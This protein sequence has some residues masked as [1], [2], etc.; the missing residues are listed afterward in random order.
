MMPKIA[1][2]LLI[3]LS[4]GACATEWPPGF[5]GPPAVWVPDVA[6]SPTPWAPAAV[7]GNVAGDRFID[8]DW[9]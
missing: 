2:A 3:A 1:L 9:R 5:V 6:A 7:A 4:L 8:G